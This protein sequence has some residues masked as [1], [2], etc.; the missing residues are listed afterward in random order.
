MRFNL[1]RFTQARFNLVRFTQARFNLVRF[2]QARFNLTQA[3]FNLVRFTQ[4]RFNLVR[5]NQ[6]RFNQARFNQSRELC[7]RSH[8]RRQRAPTS[9]PTP[10]RRYDLSRTPRLPATSR[11]LLRSRTA[12]TIRLRKIRPVMA[13]QPPH[14]P[15]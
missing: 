15:R 5:F 9:P 1:V 14:R 4:A 7:S 12:D 10:C 6:A 2:N 8:T 11:W 13:R 3:R